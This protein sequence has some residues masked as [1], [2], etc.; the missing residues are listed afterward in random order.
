MAAAP[1]T[2]VLCSRYG[3]FVGCS[4]LIL[5]IAITWVPHSLTLQ[6]TAASYGL[7]ACPTL[8]NASTAA[9]LASCTAAHYQYCATSTYNTLDMH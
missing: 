7:W 5:T 3:S 6:Q 8:K 4:R 2:A 1:L 9:R